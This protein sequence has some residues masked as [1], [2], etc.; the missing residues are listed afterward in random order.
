MKYS[1]LFFILFF[2]LLSYGEE[3]EITM[4]VKEGT[5]TIRCEN[6]PPPLNFSFFTNGNFMDRF[7]QEILEM[8]FKM[9][10]VKIREIII[11]EGEIVKLDFNVEGQ[12]IILSER[13]VKV[14]GE[15]E[16]RFCCVESTALALREFFNSEEPMKEKIKWFRRIACSWN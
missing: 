12:R 13:S 14:A 3:K 10:D 9:K 16:Y 15:P 5:I 8:V 2:A 1:I 6:N 11:R 4:S 7:R